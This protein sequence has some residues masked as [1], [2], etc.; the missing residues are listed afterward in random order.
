[1]ISSQQADEVMKVIE[2]TCRDCNT[3][4]IKVGEDVTWKNLGRDSSKQSFG[5][6]GRKG[7]YELTIPLLGQYQVENAAVAVTALECLVDRGFS[8]SGEHIKE[9]LAK[10]DWPGRL[11]VLNRNPL[12]IADGAHNPNSVIKLKEALKQ[13]F[14]FER[15]ILIFGASSDKD[16]S[17]MIAELVPMF[18]RVIIT[19]SIH[20]RSMVV[21]KIE[22][23]FRKFGVEARVT[24][25]ISDALP[26]ALDIAEE[27][28]N[29]CVTGSLFVVAGAI[30]QAGELGLTG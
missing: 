2:R 7:K 12:V 4:L 29:I 23:E 25:D 19:R 8:I 14:N 20:P 28:D 15:G 24:D 17:G 1:V 30:E 26:L 22:A 11:Q 3:P 6:N 18:D 21:D 27:E 9:G 13:Y 10:V 16:I 5:L